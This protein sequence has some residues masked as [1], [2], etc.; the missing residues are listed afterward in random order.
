MWEIFVSMC[1]TFHDAGELY[2]E[3]MIP[4]LQNYVKYGAEHLIAN[5]PYLDETVNLISIALAPV[6][7]NNNNGMDGVTRICA[8]KLAETIMLTLRGHIDRYIPQFIQLAVS[9]FQ[10]NQPMVF[11]C[12]IHMLE[13]VL[14][15]FY[16]NPRLALSAVDQ[17]GYLL[18]IFGIWLGALD[19]L[20]RVHDK[21]LSIFAI[22]SLLSLP[23]NDIPVAVRDDWWKLL[24][25]STKLLR[26]LPDAIQSK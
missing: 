1:Q 22:A 25:A 15:C 24:V 18:N 14:N 2:F 12:K 6:E 19:S 5:P 10:A 4:S 11:S 13:V 26:T 8:C 7:D 21:T 16:Y 9:S 17:T 23:Q 20:T 3:D